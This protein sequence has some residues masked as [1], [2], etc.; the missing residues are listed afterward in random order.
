MA[1]ITFT[2]GASLAAAVALAT[3]P[4]QTYTGCI[5]NGGDL[6]NVA[7]GSEP[8]KSCGPKH[9][10]IS[11]NETGPQGPAGLQ[12]PA[13]PQ[14]EPGTID[15]AGQL[16]PADGTVR[17]FNNAGLLVCTSGVFDP[18]VTAPTIDTAAV[19]FNYTTL[20]YEVVLT[21][22]AGPYN[23]IPFYLDDQCQHSFVQTAFSGAD[24][25]FIL[26][27]T[28]GPASSVAELQYIEQTMFANLTVY[29]MANQSSHISLCSAGLPLTELE[30]GN[31]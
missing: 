2:L 18:A 6:Y 29:A 15:L 1:A 23:Q 16:C 9:T 19:T 22:E 24:G 17:G 4:D 8:L 26:D 13:G 5:D 31:Q 27:E 3:T 21:G 28:L 11:W 14:G 12:G 7:V 30:T 10:Q 20:T 25:T